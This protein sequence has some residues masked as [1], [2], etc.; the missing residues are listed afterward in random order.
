MQVSKDS[1]RKGTG[2]G[3]DADCVELVLVGGL[4]DMHAAYQL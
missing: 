3:Y 4:Y 1:P 2:L